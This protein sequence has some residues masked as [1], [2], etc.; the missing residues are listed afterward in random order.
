MRK[1][2]CN[3]SSSAE[4]DVNIIGEAST[5]GCNQTIRA[6]RKFLEIEFKAVDRIAY[7]IE[8]F[9]NELEANGSNFYQ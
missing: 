3:G 2:S 8:I 4:V 5:G 1:I 9:K 6:A 7:E